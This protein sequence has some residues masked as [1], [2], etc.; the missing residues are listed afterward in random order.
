MIKQIHLH[1]FSILIILI[2][3]FAFYTP[4]PRDIFAEPIKQPSSFTLYPVSVKCNGNVPQILLDWSFA[5]NAE[6]YLIQRKKV[7]T[8]NWSN[9]LNSQ[10]KTI[11]SFED[12]HWKTDYGIDSFV[13]RVIAVN[14]SKRSFSNEISF[15][16]PDCKSLS[17][18]TT[19][20]QLPPNII[21]VNLATMT[22]EYPLS[23]STGTLAISN[24]VITPTNI[25]PSLATKTQ[26]TQTTPPPT[27]LPTNNNTSMPTTTPPVQR[28]QVPVPTTITTQ[29]TNNTKM[30][31][32]LKW[33]AYVGWQDNAMSNFESLVGKKT[34][35]EMVFSHW[36]NQKNFP[37]EYASR[38]GGAGKTMVIFWEAVD[39]NRDYFNQPEYSFDAVLSGKLDDFFIRYASQAKQYGKPVILIPYS[40]F[41]GNWFPWCATCGT[42]TP[43]K[44]IDSYR[45]INK[46]FVDV[47]NVKF[48]W[49]PNNDSLPDTTANSIEKFYPGDAY[50]DYVGVDGFNFGGSAEQT[51]KQVFDN[52]LQ[53]LKNYNKPIY[54]FSMATHENINKATWIKN[55]LT[56]EL[57]KYPEVKGFLWFNKN[58]EKDW[59]V[60]SNSEALD[61]FKKILP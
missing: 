61:A 6:K 57:Y 43:Q 19:T 47:P 26:P 29:I 20:G 7:S 11:N 28:P 53:K 37:S 49:V 54:I 59:R 27:T 5:D 3:F 41:N 30:P 31:S 2:I 15:A 24:P 21:I 40:E 35:M 22:P 17:S 38:I 23:I 32:Y 39:Y 56:E 8:L 46:F 4:K 55:A 45:Y 42:N 18:A 34:D 58:K 13:Y 48:A 44:F 51:F 1:I 50:V 25:S 52:S 9:I 16:A 10:I 60:N 33:G 12:N 36:G 14:K